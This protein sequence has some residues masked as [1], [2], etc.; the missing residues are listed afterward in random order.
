VHGYSPTY[1]LS[2]PPCQPSSPNLGTT[3]SAGGLVGTVLND[4]ATLTGG[5]NP[6]G[7]ITFNLF[8]PTTGTCDTTPIYTR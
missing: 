8:G 5:Y 4:T 3:P 1:N 7:S 2:V 6:T